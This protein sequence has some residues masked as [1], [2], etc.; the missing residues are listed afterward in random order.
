MTTTETTL[1]QQIDMGAG[2]TLDPAPASWLP[3][4]V[5]DSGVVRGTDPPRHEWPGNVFIWLN[6]LSAIAMGIAAAGGILGM[7][8]GYGPFPGEIWMVGTLAV[9][10]VFQRYLARNVERFTR[11]GW[12]GAVATLSC[13]ALAKAAA[14]VA[15]PGSIIG[16]GFGITIDLL[17]LQYFWAQR[18]DFDIDLDL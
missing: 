16:A 2:A 5:G 12:F 8:L 14:V 3:L 11:W 18:R 9:G 13:A 15:D 10:A 1:G 17:W 6:K 7:L 4:T